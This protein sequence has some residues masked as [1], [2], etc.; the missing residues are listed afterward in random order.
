MVG[1]HDTVLQQSLV[2]YGGV[3]VVAPEAGTVVHLAILNVVFPSVRNA[4]QHAAG[5]APVALGGV[6]EVG[7]EEQNI[8]TLHLT[9]NGGEALK[10]EINAIYVNGGW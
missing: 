5:S 1:K 10:G 8:P 4:E 7:V 9:V 2:R 6:Q 3:D